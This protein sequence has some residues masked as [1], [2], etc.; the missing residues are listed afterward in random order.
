[1]SLVEGFRK[2]FQ[3]LLERV[4][5]RRLIGEGG[6]LGGSR[7]QIVGGGKILEQISKGI[8]RLVEIAKER[9]PN[10]IPTVIERLKTYEPGKRIKELLPSTTTETQTPTSTRTERKILR[11]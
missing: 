6:V 3:E 2:R 10:I 5:T 4:R 8:D 11:E 7:G 9:R 1:M